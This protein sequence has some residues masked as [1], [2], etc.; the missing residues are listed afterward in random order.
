[1]HAWHYSHFVDEGKQKLAKHPDACAV[2]LEAM[3]KEDEYVQACI[4]KVLLRLSLHAI[5]RHGIVNWT[6]ESNIKDWIRMACNPKDAAYRDNINKIVEVVFSGCQLKRNFHSN[7][8][9]LIALHR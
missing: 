7:N 2:L 9:W 1:M 8:R 6:P 5:E 4:T 3:Q